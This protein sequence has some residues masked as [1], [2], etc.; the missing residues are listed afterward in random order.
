MARASTMLWSRWCISWHKRSRRRWWRRN[1]WPGQSWRRG[2]R[3][4][5]R[6]HDR[7]ALRQQG[8]PQ[9]HGKAVPP[10]KLVKL[11]ELVLGNCRLNGLHLGQFR[12]LELRVNDRRSMCPA[13][14]EDVVIVVLHVLTAFILILVVLLRRR[15]PG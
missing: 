11:V 1:N 3:R 5:D 6:R 8:V 9:L 12:R 10:T 14:V 13:V 2:V 4:S 7:P 15:A